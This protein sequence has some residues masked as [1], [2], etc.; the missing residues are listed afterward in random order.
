MKAYAL[1]KHYD[2]MTYQSK[3]ADDPAMLKFVEPIS[4]YLSEKFDEIWNTTTDVDTTA[5]T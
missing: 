5:V 4:P 2:F 3:M 1:M